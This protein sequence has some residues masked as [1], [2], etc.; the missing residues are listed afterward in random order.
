MWSV[1]G[2]GLWVVGLGMGIKGVVG[3]TGL[4]GSRGSRDAWSSG[5]LG[6]GW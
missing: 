1:Q 4:W 6:W 2:W 5:R 3:S